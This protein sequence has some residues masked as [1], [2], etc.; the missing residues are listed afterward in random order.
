MRLSL[1][2]IDVAQPCLAAW[3]EMR[4]GDGARFCEHCQKHVHDLSAMSRDEAERLVCAS[5][6][7]LCIRFARADDGQVMTLDYRSKPVK[8]GW[9]WRV[10]T[11]LSVVAA[12]ITGGVNALVFRSQPVPV[13]IPTPPAPRGQMVMGAMM[14]R[15][16]PPSPSIGDSATSPDAVPCPKRN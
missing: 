2:Q 13:V 14:P 3:E 1:E 16:L 6:G 9:S 8:L 4:G 5:G 10:W 15:T 7:D 12:L 11:L